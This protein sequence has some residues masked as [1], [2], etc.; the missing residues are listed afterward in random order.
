MRIDLSPSGHV[1]GTRR[2]PTSGNLNGLSELAGKDV[3]IV[4]PN[5]RPIVRNT[6]ADY[7]HE[8]QKIAERNAKRAAK[9]WQALQK[10]L[11]RDRK[12]ALKLAKDQLELARSQLDMQRMLRRPV[13]AHA[14]RNVQKRVRRARKQVRL[15]ETWIRTRIPFRATRSAKTAA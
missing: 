14:R 4:V 2:V 1:Y 3:L 13:V 15:A 5:G 7:F 6:V 12:A 9:E 11:P 10:R 8:W